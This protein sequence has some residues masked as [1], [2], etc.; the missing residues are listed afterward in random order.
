MQAEAAP[1]VL[2]TH[3][4]HEDFRSSSSSSFTAWGT[5]YQREMDTFYDEHKQR[6]QLAYGVFGRRTFT[7]NEVVPIPQ[8]EQRSNPFTVIS[9]IDPHI[10]H[11]EQGAFLGVTGKKACSDSNCI[12]GFYAHIPISHIE[13]NTTHES[14]LGERLSDVAIQRDEQINNSYAYRFDFLN[15]LNIT[16]TQQPI[17]ACDTAPLRIAQI[18]VTETNQPCNIPVTL[19][20]SPHGTPQQTFSVPQSTASK[21]PVLSAQPQDNIMTGDRRRFGP[22]V[23]YKDVCNDT[24]YTQ[25]WFLTPTICN[26][27]MHP[28]AR[29]I[30]TYIN[31]TI[32]N[33]PNSVEP[34][35]SSRGISLEQ[36]NETHFGDLDIHASIEGFSSYYM[37][38][39]MPGVRFPTG[40]DKNPYNVL[41]QP[42]GNNGHVEMLLDAYASWDISSWLCTRIYGRY[43]H[44]FSHIEQR[45]ANAAGVRNIG[46]LVTPHVDWNYGILH[47]DL[48]MHMRYGVMFQ[49]AYELFV[50]GKE[51]IRIPYHQDMQAT[52]VAR[53]ASRSH[54][55]HMHIHVPWK[56]YSLFAQYAPM[57][58]GKNI[59]REIKTWSIG[60]SATF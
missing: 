38:G 3:E 5:Y 34:S 2:H 16:P 42:T 28:D 37:W 50:Q 52:N 6:K 26:N 14:S 33:T 60:V 17:V 35:L 49:V 31:N 51:N 4:T 25:N 11:K 45:L 59:A 39:F 29:I 43:G 48:S 7:L 20:A 21:T 23:S 40:K 55:L 15:Q 36:H 58:S 10:E 12:I 46:V 24:S 8:Q 1:E 57:L 27:D 41:E 18:D 32:N 56:A 9:H 30:Q 53:P 19:L 44:S 22:N 54:S 47:T 13:V